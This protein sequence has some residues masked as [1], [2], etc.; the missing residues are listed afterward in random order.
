[1]GAAPPAP[2]IV[3]T[4]AQRIMRV[5]L[6]RPDCEVSATAAIFVDRSATGDPKEVGNL[7]TYRASGLRRLKNRLAILRTVKDYNSALGLH[8]RVS[9][10]VSSDDDDS[11]FYVRHTLTKQFDRC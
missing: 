7:L 1:M 3:R 10:A 4:Q 9:E 5:C 2:D 6:P 8:R 11:R